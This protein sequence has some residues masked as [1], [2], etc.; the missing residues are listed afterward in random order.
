[1]ADAFS[2]RLAA[3]EVVYLTRALELPGI[4]GFDPAVF[5]AL[6]ADHQALAL[7][8]A[9]R[10]LRARGA[11]RWR[12]HEQREVDTLAAAVVRRCAAPEWTLLLEVQAA[13]TTPARVAYVVSEHIA[14]EVAAPEPGVYRFTAFGDP[15][16][17]LAR[18]AGWLPSDAPSAGSVTAIQV[19]R[20]VLAQ[21][22]AA[23]GPDA[24][25][26]ILAPHLPPASAAPLAAMLQT[27]EQRV[28]LALWVGAPSATRAPRAV[29]FFLGPRGLWSA[30]SVPGDTAEFRAQTPDSA[31]AAIAELAAPAIAGLRPAPLA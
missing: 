7:A 10:T 29:T 13:N 20:T 22:V 27:A 30:Q 6:D 11:I 18:L 31:R 9:D 23:P 15:D 19:P 12:E 24:I 3:E 8:V 26:A 21:L 2:T 4:V 17:T 16:D 1:M 25:P 14:V 5:D 28:S